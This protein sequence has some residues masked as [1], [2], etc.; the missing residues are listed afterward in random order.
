MRSAR[1]CYGTCS[2]FC[3]PWKP[4]SYCFSLLASRQVSWAVAADGGENGASFRV[5]RPQYRIP[6]VWS[7]S[8]WQRQH[9]GPSWFSH[10][11]NV[12]GSSLSVGG[13]VFSCL[14]PVFYKYKK[15]KG[16]LREEAWGWHFPGGDQ[17]FCCDMRCHL[18]ISSM[19]ITLWHMFTLS[20]PLCFSYWASL[21][22][23]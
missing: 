3:A 5:P 10:E 18:K 14:Q 20:C 13:K 19:F 21:K 23:L 8:R 4:L 15:K 22:N 12:V 6:S 9:A 16:V 2:D 11:G 7:R 1:H 17:H